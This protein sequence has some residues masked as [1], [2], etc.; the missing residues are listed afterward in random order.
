MNQCTRMKKNK[1]FLGIWYL[2]S[3][4]LSRNKFKRYCSF[5]ILLNTL[6]YYWFYLLL[7]IFFRLKK[8]KKQLQ[9]TQTRTTPTEKQK[10]NNISCPSQKI[11]SVHHTLFPLWS[12]RYHLYII[13]LQKLPH[14]KFDSYLTD[15]IR[16]TH[17]TEN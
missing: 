10:P 13:I 8:K 15:L 12:I 11:K 9:Q 17:S 14:I 5:T 6:D 2:N 16:N 7:M 3:K 1:G 4:W